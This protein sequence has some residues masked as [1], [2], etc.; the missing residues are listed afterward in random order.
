MFAQT[1][2]PPV[3][4]S[5]IVPTNPLEGILKSEPDPIGG[6]GKLKSEP[7]PIGGIGKLKSEPDPIGG[8]GK[9]QR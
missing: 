6:I 1:P 7:D 4:Y 9:V 5:I 8:I 2:P 3:T